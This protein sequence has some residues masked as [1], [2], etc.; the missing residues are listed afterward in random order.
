MKK[1]R[2]IYTA[3]LI[4]FIA[5]RIVLYNLN[6]SNV[7]RTVENTRKFSITVRVCTQ[8]DETDKSY[9]A[10]AK[11]KEVKPKI[12]IDKI[13]L[14][15]PKDRIDGLKYGEIIS[16]VCKLTVPEDEL[17]DG[18]FSY[19]NYLKT[20]N[21]A[22]TANLADKANKNCTIYRLGN[23]KSIFVKIQDMIH[24]MQ[25]ACIRHLETYF[26]GDNLGLIK[27][28][29]T[30]DRDSITDK[31]TQTYIN[32]GTYH[33]V[34]V[35]GLHASVLICFVAFPLIFVRNKGGRKKRVRNII[36][37]I[38]ALFL[39]MFTGYG[40]SVYKV[41]FMSFV[42]LASMLGK[43][44]YNAV[45]SLLYSFIGILAFMP[46][47]VS[48]AGLWLSASSTY[49]ILITDKVKA[50]I[51]KRYEKISHIEDGTSF[52]GGVLS[53]LSA[54]PVCVFYFS[55]VSLL[56]PI[57]N[58][59]V[60]PL[61][62]ILVVCSAIFSVIGFLP[63]FVCS[64]LAHIPGFIATLINLITKLAAGIPFSSIYVSNLMFFVLLF[65]ALVTLLIYTAFKNNKKR[66]CAALVSTVFAISVIICGFSLT[67][68]KMFIN[69]LNVENGSCTIVTVKSGMTSR[70]YMF[71]CG[72][73]NDPDVAN[74][75]VIP[76]MSTKGISKIDTLFVSY[77][78]NTYANGVNTLINNNMIE[79]IVMYDTD[80][81]N[82]KDADAVMRSIIQNAALTDT[83]VKYVKDGDMLSFKDFD[84]EVINNADYSLFKADNASD[85]YRIKYG[86]TSALICGGAGLKAL[87]DLSKTHTLK[88][89]LLVMTKNKFNPAVKSFLDKC[90]P[91]YAAVSSQGGADKKLIDYFK[92]NS[93]YY[94]MTAY[95]KTITY[96]SDGNDF[97]L[98]KVKR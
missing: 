52:L 35:S 2:I 83:N 46:Y 22:L 9:T 31:M 53:T 94:N 66:T 43:R 20:Q 45:N 57:C 68:N 12:N 10:Y 17:N 56:A 65:A 71:D 40:V 8:V 72:S 19:R 62:S 77:T 51:Y 3:L 81:L 16:F 75:S 48:D 82:N 30:G 4:V 23:D 96:E 47:K 5:G 58:V 13:S 67:C 92:E 91:Y 6:L 34:A 21:V 49:G 1:L 98:K 11:V 15:I 61:A 55:R 7:Y 90:Q 25:N 39:L 44:K 80:S 59:I 54:L 24:N 18:G 74:N 41:L 14:V 33:I 79:N 73:E 76:Y 93:I 78:D 89:N 69:I 86:S 37:I 60:V 27:A 95:D 63:D 38:T 50:Y 36:A 64:A 85:L 29:I 84:V 88:T 26:K 32:S 97:K 42:V 28:I 87:N 70:H